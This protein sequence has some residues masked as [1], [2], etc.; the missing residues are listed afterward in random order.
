MV[1]PK[2]EYSRGRGQMVLKVDPA[3]PHP[4]QV[5]PPLPGN[6]I[7][8]H[9]VNDVGV[10][11]EEVEKGLCAGLL[12]RAC[13]KGGV[14]QPAPYRMPTT[15][16]KGKL[17][18]DPDD[19][20]FKRKVEQATYSPVIPFY[21]G[22]RETQGRYKTGR[23]TSHGQAV[24]RH[25][26]RL[27]KDMSKGG[28]P[29]ANAT[30]T[31]QDMWNSGAPGS[32]GIPDALTK[33]PLRP[34]LAGPGR[35][36]MVL[37]AKRLAAL[38]AMIHDYDPAERV[39]LVAHSQ[40]CMLSL[41]A[42]AF[43]LQEGKRPAD[44]LVLTHPPYS[45][46]NTALEAVAKSLSGFGSFARIG[47]GEDAA[48]AGHYRHIAGR[49]TLH[50][51]LQTL[52]N[53]VR[54]VHDRRNTSP[55]LP[56]PAAAKASGVVGTAWERGQDRDNAGKVYLYFCP[57][58][59]TVA[60]A[61]VQGIGWQGVPD[62]L[63]GTRLDPRRVEQKGRLGQPDRLAEENCSREP[64]KE[65]GRSFLQRVFTAKQRPDPRTGK[66]GAVQVGC[67]PHDFALK[68]KGEDDH[69]HVMPDASGNRAGLPEASPGTT[70]LG[71]IPKPQAFQREGLRTITGEKLNRP[72]AAELTAGSLKGSHG[73]QEEVDPIDA[74]IATT[75][76]YG[77]Q[78][79]PQTLMDDP[80]EPFWHRKNSADALGDGER[81]AL[82]KAMNQD[83]PPEE[84]CKVQSAS[85]HGDGKLLV[86][87]FETP[88][89]VRLRL[90]QRGVS[91]RSFHGAIFGSAANHRY[92][93]AYDVSIGQG[94]AASDPA[95]YR[96][97]CAV[98]DW[99]LKKP[100][101]TERLRPSILKWSTFLSEHAD[102]WACEPA[103]RKA[104]IEGNCD[105]YST[106]VLPKLPLLPDE[107]PPALVCE[108]TQGYR[109]PPK[110]GAA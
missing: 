37:A 89:E 87:R 36:Y 59:M 32:L 71:V 31:L 56:D 53:I 19:V 105:Y 12:E 9:G 18:V 69:A 52:A 68:L 20:F 54:G 72:W 45:L 79:L 47:G 3:A 95:F 27:D 103:E 65:L 96:Y 29:F 100:L 22:Y 101:K 88:N 14:Y 49:Q 92:V 94:L 62:L 51:R 74:A 11:Y 90:Q 46:E 82:Q 107:M 6:I 50:A 2:K 81:E 93:T 35:L 33:D 104:L 43:L 10:S 40:G 17:L 24:D 83:K 97:L 70:W 39:S 21:W 63:S 44:T 91:S 60:L 106:G 66:A 4:A 55:W 76:D 67:E 26:N 73:K 58:D 28:G 38:V 57:E 102:Y 80:R 98:A 34:V 77:A 75:S 108:T 86:T 110:A 30:T 13:W 25:G 15:D 8:I 5:R 23:E 64:L 78:P 1:Y 84:R 16:D 85:H 99:R 61:N 42:Q 41:L 7:L 109:V 48:M